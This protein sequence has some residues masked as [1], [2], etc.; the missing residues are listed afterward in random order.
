MI[1]VGLIGCGFMGGMHA[2]CY[3]QIKN[4]KL[5][6]VADVRE[7]KA[8]AVAGEDTK[9]YATGM[10]LIENADVDVVDICLPTYLHTS[11]AV[12][13]M[14]KGKKVFLE[15]PACLTKE[16]GKLLLDVQKETG[17]IVQVGQ[18]LRFMDEYLFLKKLNDTKEYGNLISATLARKSPLPGWAWE[19]W[20]HDTAKSGSVAHDMHIHDV[21]FVRFLLGEPDSFTTNVARDKDGVLSHIFT[22]FVYGST[23]VNTE[24]TWDLPADFPFSPSFLLK[25]EKATIVNDAQGLR[26]YLSDGGCEEIKLEPAFKGENDIGGNI[27]DLGG[28]YVELK[29]FIDK[30][31]AGETPDVAPLSEGVKSA[32]LVLDEVASVGGA[33]I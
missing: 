17:A 13:A 4:A 6:A 19:G 10:E 25:F 15:K 20:L 26:K 28:Y 14:K 7:E 11:H 1:K 8:L 3:K 12:A 9:V 31:D 18:V 21:D 24:A 23:C 22:S 5:V 2:A 30:L 29:Y 33:K 16:E 27:S 32:D